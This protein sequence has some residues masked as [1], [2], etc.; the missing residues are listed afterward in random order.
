MGRKEAIAAATA[1]LLCAGHAAAQTHASNTYPGPPCRPPEFE[2]LPQAEDAKT[3]DKLKANLYDYEVR[4]YNREV[5]A[6][7]VCI[8]KYIA[9]ANS[10][11]QR[12]QAQANEEAKRIT[13]KANA[14][15]AMIQAQIRKATANAKKISNTPAS[16]LVG[17]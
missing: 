12:I 16:A 2:V 5:E 8:R 11:A 7:S 9:K 3:P 1:I 13:E 15:V 10:D 6:Y 14:S 17:K 4:Q